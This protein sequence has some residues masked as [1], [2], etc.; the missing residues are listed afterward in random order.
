MHPK[1]F[2]AS[3][4]MAKRAIM[5]WLDPNPNERWE[6]HP[7]WFNKRPKPPDD[8]AFLD[9]YAAALGVDIVNGESRDK[10]KLL[11]VAQKCRVHLLLDPD[12]RL[13]KPQNNTR[14]KKHVTVH[15]FIAFVK[16]PCRQDKLTLVYDQSYRR[17]GGD[18]WE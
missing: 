1:Y 13:W 17:G 2:G 18:I 11:E 12:T 16:S 4:D 10:N 5:G 15:Q 14:S 7:M 9:K 8:R 6:A 3:H